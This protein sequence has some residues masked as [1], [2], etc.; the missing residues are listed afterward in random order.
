MIVVSFQK[1]FVEH[2]NCGASTETAVRNTASLLAAARTAGVP[3][4]Y[5]VMILD[6]LDDRTLAQRLR[7]SLTERCGR[8]SPWVGI[9][10]VVAV[11]PGDHVVEKTVT[12]GFYQTRLEGLLRQL[13][14]DELIVVGTSTSGVSAPP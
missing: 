11:Q 14:I 1:A 13:S 5:L 7:S 12:S 6:S 10:P 8:G 9:S 3:V 2:E 4:I